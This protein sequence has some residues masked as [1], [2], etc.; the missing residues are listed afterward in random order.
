[1][2]TSRSELRRQDWADPIKRQHFTDGIRIAANS[3][4][5]RKSR[6][7]AS[8]A[9]WADPVMRE[10]IIAAIRAAPCRARG[11]VPR[12]SI[13]RGSLVSLIDPLEVLFF[14][15]SHDPQNHLD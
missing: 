7:D 6:S 4:S 14:G 8:K 13:V 10:L 5:R 2:L 1:M 12:Q 11:E 15:K 3:D 9:R